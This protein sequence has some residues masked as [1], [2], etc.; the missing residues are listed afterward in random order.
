MS[1][2]VKDAALHRYGVDL[3]DADIAAIDAQ[4]RSGR[5]LLRRFERDNYGPSEH[6]TVRVGRISLCVVVVRGRIMTVLPPHWLEPEGETAIGAAFRR[7]ISNGKR[8]CH[9]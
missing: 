9:V 1:Q 2:H 4:C 8:N 5:H 7:A 3:N 6:H